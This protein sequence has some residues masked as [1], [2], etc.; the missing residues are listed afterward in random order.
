MAVMC[1]ANGI[2]A[3]V[4]T[5]YAPGS[6][7]IVGNKYVY[8]DR[9]AHA[10][11]E[12]YFDGLG[13]VLFDPTQ[14]SSDIFSFGRFRE[15]VRDTSTFL[16]NLFVIDPTGAK[17]TIAGFFVGLYN[18]AV[19]FAAAHWRWA[20]LIIG[21]FIAV[22]AAVSLLRR[23]A[24]KARALVPENEIVAAYIELSSL[25]R[26]SSLGREPYDT[27]REFKRRLSDFLIA[28]P[29]DLS[30][31]ITLYDVAAFSR[32][33]LSSEDISWCREF[34]AHVREYVERSKEGLA[35]S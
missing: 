28:S 1:R 32:R 12:V 4:V 3:R 16:E 20:P 11:V 2:P 5:G 13:W 25:L 10:W 33:P 26:V 7:S 35:S 9:N 21:V 15:F 23:R 8:R 22:A 31:F 19:P 30:R 14:S 27:S 34:L 6:Y 17:E 29:E 18:L 24:R